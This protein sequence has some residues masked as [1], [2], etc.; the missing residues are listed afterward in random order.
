MNKKIPILCA[1]L[2]AL[3]PLAAWAGRVEFRDEAA[4]I[5]PVIRQDIAARFSA[6]PFS[7]RVIT[8]T[9]SPSRAALESRAA[10]FLTSPDMIVVGIDPAHRYTVIRVGSGLNLEPGTFS[11][12]GVRLG[13][14][15]ASWSGPSMRAAA[16]CAFARGGNGRRF[17]LRQTAHRRFTWRKPG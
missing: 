1:L 11:Q 9:A 17:F 6:F 3:L 14:G 10:S 13:T 7:A 15:F 4:I 5:A 2:L 12:I 16:S 8:S